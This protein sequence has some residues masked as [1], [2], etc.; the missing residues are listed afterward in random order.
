MAWRLVLHTKQ[1]RV[2]AVREFK[3][4]KR[5]VQWALQNSSHVTKS[6]VRTYNACLF[7]S[8]TSRG[9]SSREL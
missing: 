5:A 2:V 1:L 6:G 8:Q 3:S 7:E 9:Q 4:K